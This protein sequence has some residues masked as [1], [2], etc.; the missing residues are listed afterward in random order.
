[1]GTKPDCESR[2]FDQH[3]LARHDP[4]QLAPAVVSA[5]HAK[6]DVHDALHFTEPLRVKVVGHLDVFVVRPGYLEGEAF[7]CELNELQA[8]V[9][10][11]GIVIVGLDVADA[12]VIVFKLTLNDKVGV[13]GVRQ[14]KVIV[15]G[16]LAIERDLKILVAGLPDRYVIGVEFHWAVALLQ[17]VSFVPVSTPIARL[18]A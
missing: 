13:I 5:L 9:A 16:G 18:P 6:N 10:S 1:M 11:V 2:R 3:S 8:E 17:C 12:A 7:G 15:L 4:R 14:I